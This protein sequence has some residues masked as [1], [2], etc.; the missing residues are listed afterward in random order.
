M[1]VNSVFE[2]ETDIV[3]RVQFFNEYGE[4]VATHHYDNP[5]K[6][7][8]VDEADYLLSLY[9]N[10]LYYELSYN[11]KGESGWKRI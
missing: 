2:K 5:N 7:L 1:K 9:F 11:K 8:V 10:C 4:L 6:D 3:Y